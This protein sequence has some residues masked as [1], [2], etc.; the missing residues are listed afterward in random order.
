[1]DIEINGDFDSDDYY[2]QSQPIE[3]PKPKVE[4]EVKLTKEQEMAKYFEE[5][6]VKS[7]QIMIKAGLSPSLKS[8]KNVKSNLTF[9]LGNYVRIADIEENKSLIHDKIYEQ[10]IHLGHD[11]SKMEILTW[12]IK[13]FIID[14]IFDYHKEIKIEQFINVISEAMNKNIVIQVLK[15]QVDTEFIEN[16]ATEI[17]KIIPVYKEP[18]IKGS[19]RIRN[20]GKVI[21]D[22][23]PYL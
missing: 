2:S 1:M 7:E 21:S 12:V 6:K 10:L 15:Q 9:E 22:Y 18:T 17:L 20:N 5:A 19:S 23:N 13:R 16:L 11:V 14:G 3:Q 4:P 8:S